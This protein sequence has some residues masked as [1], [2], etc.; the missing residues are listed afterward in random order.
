M[1]G[2]GSWGLSRKQS[3]DQLKMSATDMGEKKKK[4]HMCLVL[5]MPEPVNL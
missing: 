2:E 5:A 4:G 3:F 1:F